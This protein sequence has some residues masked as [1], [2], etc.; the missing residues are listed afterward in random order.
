AYPELKNSEALIAETLKLEEIR[1]RETLARGLKLLDEAT[2]GMKAGDRL[3]GDVAFKLYDTYGFPLD[4]TQE[5]L[6][7]RDIHVDIDGFT[8]AMEKQRAEARASWVG[9]GEGASEAQWF[10]VLDEVGRTEFLGYDT[11]EAEGQV[12]AIFKDGGRVM[13]A[14]VGETVEILTNQTPFYA[15]SGG[16]AGDQ[17]LMISPK[18]RG[19]VTDTQKKLGALHV[20]LVRVTQ[21]SFAPGD[22]VDLKVDEERRRATR[23]NHSATHL[24]HA[25]LKRVLGSHVSQ[26]GSLVTAERLRFDFSHPKPVTAQELEAI[27]V[28]VNAVIRQNSDTTT[29]LMATDQAIAAGAEAL[30]GEKYGDEVRVLSM[31][32]DLGGAEEKAY[33]VELCGGTHVHRL[34]DIGLFTIIS[35]SAVAAGVRRIEA[36]TSEH[37]RRYLAG[38]AEIAREAAGAIRTPIGELSARVAQLAEERRK[39][40]RELAEVRKQLALAG[41]AKGGGD[42]ETIAGIKTVLK[43]VEGVSPKDLKSLADGAKQQIGSGVVAFVAA[44]DGKASV[45]VGVTDDLTAKISAVDLVRAAAEALG[46]KGGGGRADM[47]QAGG[48]DNGD[49]KAALNAVRAKLKELTPA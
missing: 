36:L 14:T 1:F 6:R 8:F 25:A 44:A 12:L 30:F 22:A 48:P 47:A 38:Q 39:L 32:T 37:A 15:E 40:E 27:E 34:G 23:A 2:A 9:S 18:G 16:Q 35:E 45:V 49:I 4:L 28:Q 29:R 17:G 33:S 43:L 21:G 46:G 42:S 5:S 31:G 26:K 11:E 20:H 19:Q 13:Q 10:A 41:P 7:A 24:L 3:T